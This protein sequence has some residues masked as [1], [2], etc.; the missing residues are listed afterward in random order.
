MTALIPAAALVAI[1]A[2]RRAGIT[3][4]G[5]AIAAW[6]AWRFRKVGVAG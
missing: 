6:F 3:L 5:Y 2:L 4:L 1:L